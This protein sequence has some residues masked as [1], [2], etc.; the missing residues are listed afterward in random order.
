MRILLL[1]PPFVPEYMRNAR[2]D[3][4]S[5]SATQWYPILLGYCGAYLEAQDH[6]VKLVDAPAHHL[7]HEATRR[8]VREYKP[9]FLV[10][11]TGRM[12]EE[13]D[14]DFADSLVDELGCEA[15]LVGPYASI[16]PEK[17]LSRT[18]VVNKLVVGEFEHPVGEIAEGRKLEDIWNL[19]YKDGGRIRSNPVR[20]YLTREE[21]DEDWTPNK[22][23]HLTVWECTQ[24]LIRAIQVEGE[25]SAVRGS[26]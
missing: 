1:S 17:T 10:V 6:K 23:T 13:N 9:D 4:V 3:F 11:Y 26:T 15:V 14:I 24:H 12:S 18:N 7:D 20:P 2:C 22:D 25:Y 19:I 8:I 16:Q 5:L 21:L